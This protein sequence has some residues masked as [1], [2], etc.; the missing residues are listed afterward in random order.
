MASR[1]KLRGRKSGRPPDH[2][3]PDTM[4]YT[5]ALKDPAWKNEIKW[6]N[7]IMDSNRR[8][9]LGFFKLDKLTKGEGS[10]FM[11]A[12]IQ[13]LNR[14]EVFDDSREDIKELAGT[15][16]QFQL[17]IRVKNFIFR[18][19]SNH[20]KIQ[21]LRYIYEL[22]QV[23]KAADEEETETWEEYW[24]R[25]LIDNEWADSFFIRATALYL[26]M[27]IQIMETGAKKETPYYIIEGDL[28]DNGSDD[29]LYIGYIS[30]IHN[31][32]LHKSKQ[33]AIL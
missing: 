1:L 32:S 5:D 17:R 27:N 8:L 20:P 23:A 28:D 19:K 11:I 24:E 3:R 30:K 29:I 22:D 26:N 13:Q 6:G 33:R 4:N 9:G 31:Q 18:D 12:I 7:Q 15:R 25:M 10:C 16:D 14:D 21:W 2:R